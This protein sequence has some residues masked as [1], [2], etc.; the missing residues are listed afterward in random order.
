MYT[1]CTHWR[2]ERILSLVDDKDLAL[3]LPLYSHTLTTSPSSLPPLFLLLLF[4]S[5]SDSVWPVYILSEEVG[6]RVQA[7]GLHIVTLQS[8][9]SA[10][11][12]A[13]M[14]I[15]SPLDD[16]PIVTWEAN[17][18]RRTGSLGNLVFIEIGRRCDGGPGL[19]WMY[20]TPEDSISFRE[21]VTR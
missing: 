7:L 19:I 20:A 8:T 9:L 17:K 2:W 6:S 10:N 18:M 15:I 1:L 3:P 4:F 16:E 11:K 14:T 21:T 13:R 12:P 5:F